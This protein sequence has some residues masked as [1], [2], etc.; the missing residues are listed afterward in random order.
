MHLRIE[1]FSIEFEKIATQN[2][3]ILYY[4][5]KTSEVRKILQFSGNRFDTYKLD[6]LVKDNI[7]NNLEVKINQMFSKF[8]SDITI[9]DN[10]IA[11]DY[12]QLGLVGKLSLLLEILIETHLLIYRNNDLRYNSKV[13]GTLLLVRKGFNIL[14]DKTSN[15]YFLQTKII[16]VENLKVIDDILTIKL[17]KAIN[18]VSVV[19]MFENTE[20]ETN[21]TI[22][23]ISSMYKN[24]I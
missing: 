23:D 14:K 7:I 22:K 12:L 5:T 18:N 17:G 21:L 11:Y 16:P 8:E 10:S 1:N 20:D 4:T 6:F 19:Y 9:D 3:G 2:Q 15:Y 13:T 24:F